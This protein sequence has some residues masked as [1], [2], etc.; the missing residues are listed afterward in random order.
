[1]NKENILFAVVAL[2]V[3][4]LGGF[5][6]FSMSAKKEPVSMTTGVPAGGGSPQDYQQR[7]AEAEKIVARE[8]N[9]LQAWVQL[10][11]DYFDTDQPQK[12]INAYGKALELSP[13][14]ANILT[15]QGIMFRRVGFYD[16]AL[17]NFEKANK[18]DPKH[19]QS[20]FNIGVVYKED[21]KQPDKAIA[22]WERFL[23][24]DSTSPQAQQIKMMVEQLK[25]SPHG[26]A[27][28]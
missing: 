26:K 19:V 15:D 11:N 27:T 13:D 14:N 20:L 17:A 6:I 3:G 5:L 12:A 25:S 24:V 28:K 10:G 22:A 9:N 4:L 7:I 2:I 1:M 18:I 21:L 16:R 23:K 8:P